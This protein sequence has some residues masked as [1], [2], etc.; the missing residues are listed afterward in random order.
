MESPSDPSSRKSLFRSVSWSARSPKPT[1]SSNPTNP[2]KPPNHRPRFLPPLQPLSVSR[3]LDDW[4]S[5]APSAS[6]AA[7]GLSMITD[8]LFLGG[9]SAARNL[10]ALRSR[11][12]TH[13]LNCAGDSG[14]PSDASSGDGIEH[15]SL[16]LQDAPSEDL[17]SILYDA[18]DFIERARRIGGRVLVHCRRG[19]SRSVSVVVGYLMWK[20]RLAFEPALAVVRSARPVADPNVGFAWQLLQL[21]RRL[22][23]S[24]SGGSARVYRMAPHS[25]FDPLYLVRKTVAASDGLD[26][27]GA[28]LVHIPCSNI[29]VWVGKD[30]EPLMARSAN[31][32]A[33]QIMKYECCGGGGGGAGTVIEARE[34]MEPEALL[35]ALEGVRFSGRVEAYDA[36]YE[37]FRGGIKGGGGHNKEEEDEFPMIDSPPFRAP[38]SL[39]PSD[40]NS[41]SPSDTSSSA[42]TFSPASSDFSFSSVESSSPPVL[43]FVVRMPGRRVLTKS[44]SLAERRGS[45]AP[46]L[47][48][49]RKDLGRIGLEKREALKFDDDLVEETECSAQ[50]M[51]FG[52]PSLERVK[53]VHHGMLDSRSVFLLL[54]PV[55][56]SGNHG[57]R[58]LY[59][60]V[61]SEVLMSGDDGEERRIQWEEIGREFLDR[62]G[63][64]VDIPVQIIREH[65]EPQKFLDHLFSFHVPE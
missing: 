37:M 43:D 29:Y 56:N 55:V 19:I 13:V 36:D 57:H 9:E 28:F 60:W 50:P 7:D 61:G 40:A 3:P 52:W 31:A 63:L 6:A 58:I 4:T 65:E 23:P 38:G 51:L 15:R 21:H 42:S 34:G 62:M 59:V 26:S 2:S 49:L 45:Y 10:P 22:G 33:L 27:R 32:A 5:S 14:K 39:W 24:V 20:D 53:I 18:F 17:S 35:D 25:P 54:G 47:M 41:V 16:C 11:G 64:P 1:P 48:V 46:P 44:L 8:H 12:V 30:C